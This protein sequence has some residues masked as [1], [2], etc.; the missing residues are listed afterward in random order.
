LLGQHLRAFGGIHAAFASTA[1]AV[2]PMPAALLPTT[3]RRRPLLALRGL[4]LIAFLLREYRAGR[5]RDESGQHQQ[6]KS[7]LHVVLLKLL[8]LFS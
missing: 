2:T 5:E 6:Q 8:V 4:V 1:A 3:L 7:G